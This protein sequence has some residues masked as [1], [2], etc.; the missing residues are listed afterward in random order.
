VTV[1]LKDGESYDD[2]I[3]RFK[4]KFSKSGIAKEL[5]EKSHYEKPSIR[6]RKKRMQAQIMRSLE[7]E[8]ANKMRDKYRKQNKNRR[9]GKDDDKSNR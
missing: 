3:K 7:E 4:K 9:E 5:K 2:L 6:K 8:K 1:Y